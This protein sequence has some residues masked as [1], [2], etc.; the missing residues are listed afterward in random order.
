MYDD[1]SSIV[2]GMIAE[3]QSRMR[4]GAAERWTTK[5]KRIGSTQGVAQRR[6][7]TEVRVIMSVLRDISH[8]CMLRRECSVQNAP[9]PS[10]DCERTWLS[11]C[12]ATASSSSLS[13]PPSP[14]PPA[15]APEGTCR[16]LLLAIDSSRFCFLISTCCS[17]RFFLISSWRNCPLFLYCDRRESLSRSKPV[18]S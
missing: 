2:Q 17:S 1:R 13:A 6:Q 9:S 16:F 10:L 5:S 4:E 18:F 8:L 3:G 14:L 12:V 7:S 11:S 15:P